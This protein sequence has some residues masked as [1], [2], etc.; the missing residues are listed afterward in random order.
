MNEQQ[1]K[2]ESETARILH[3]VDAMR[4]IKDPFEFVAAAKNLLEWCRAIESQTDGYN[5]LPEAITSAEKAFGD[6]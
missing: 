1:P 5:G 4:D 2:A 3:C 6:V